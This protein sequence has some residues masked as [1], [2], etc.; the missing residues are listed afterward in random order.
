VRTGRRELSRSAGFAAVAYAFAVTM[1]ST[2]L[3]TPLYPLYRAQ[4]GF[5]ELVVTIVFA[6]YAAGVIAALLAF[7]NASD[8]V[9]RRRVLLP[10]LVAAVLSGLV[11]LT[12][13]NLTMLLVGRV[14]SG[15]AAGLF[16]GTG[17]ATLIDLAPPGRAARGGLVATLVN[18]GGLGLGPLLAGL[19]AEYAPAPLR[20]VFVVDLVLLVI[21]LVAVVLMPEPVSERRP[22]RR[23]SLGVPPAVRGVFAQA[24]LAGFAGFVVLGTF[25]GVSPAALGEVLHVGNRAAIGSV[26]FAVF[27]ASTAGQ[28]ALPA[29]GARVALPVG[30][31]VLTVGALLVA[32]SL[33]THTLALLVLGG[34]VA[35]FGQG[36]GFRAGIAAV[37]V[38]APPEDRAA[39]TSVFFLVLYIGISVPVVGIG[40]GANTAGVR[41]AGIGAA[42]AVAVLEAAAG[43]S[44]LLRPV[45]GDRPREP[46]RSAT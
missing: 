14:L 44:L 29:F 37:T 40:I 9:G 13:Q 15:I 10:A 20:T 41:T 5:S 27:A 23:P 34:V 21:A 43:I 31:G 16:T 42:L 36:L 8:A 45:A 4:L 35:G 1:L 19:L 18:M 3:P 7:G 22:L 39:V 46:A 24:A 11:F 26:V 25:T 17:T 6:A 38:A 32:V 30:A 28:L 33:W 2:T 12:E